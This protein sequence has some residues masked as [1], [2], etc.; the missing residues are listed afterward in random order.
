MSY[1][2][3]VNYQQQSDTNTT[4]TP[5]NLNTV[6]LNQIPASNPQQLYQQFQQQM[7]G[8]GNP[9]FDWNP[10]PQQP[11]PYTPPTPYQGIN[12]TAGQTG[13][14][15]GQSLGGQISGTAAP[16][17]VAPTP[18]P[19]PITF[20]HPTQPIAQ[21]GPVTGPA[22]TPTPDQPPQ[23]LDITQTPEYKSVIQQHPDWTYQTF[24]SSM[25]PGGWHNASGQAVNP[26]GTINWGGRM[27]NTP[28]LT[29]QIINGSD[30]LPV[31]PQ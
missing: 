8:I 21:P 23:M 18:T 31:A 11:A 26:D 15:T 27:Q 17:P 14:P 30:A 10:P 20:I 22:P 16:A 25:D 9:T 3:G 29:P 13:A 12:Q 24:G 2:K 7:F 28:A 1:G 19:A 5:Q 4:G 6:T